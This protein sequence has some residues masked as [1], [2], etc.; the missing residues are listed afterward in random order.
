MVFILLK[1][2]GIQDKFRFFEFHKFKIACK[3]LLHEKYVKNWYIR[4]QPFNLKRKGYGF[5]LK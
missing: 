2:I 1:F 3:K 4:E 5:L